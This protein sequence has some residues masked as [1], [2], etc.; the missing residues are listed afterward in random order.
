MRGVTVTDS[1]LARAR[2]VVNGD[3]GE[4]Y[5][6]SPE[7]TL[8]YQVRDLALGVSEETLIRRA[9]GRGIEKGTAQEVSERLKRLYGCVTPIFASRR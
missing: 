4:R 8:M 3:L 1:L 2:R 6:G 7:L 9:S 5:L